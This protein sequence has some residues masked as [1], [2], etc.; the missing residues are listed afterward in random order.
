MPPSPGDLAPDFALPAAPGEPKVRLSDYRG[1][2]PVV[3]L[4]F[5]LAF[6]AVCSD[7]MCHVAATYDRYERLDAQVLGISVDSPFV[8]RKFARECGASFPILSDFNREAAEK[9]DVLYDDY[10]GLERVSKRAAFVVDRDGRVV[11]VWVSD[12][13]GRFPDFDEILEAVEGAA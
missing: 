13:A 1:E 3:I 10:Y 4:F 12:D 8:N 5:P 7:E 11:Y 6:S 2:R 9:Y